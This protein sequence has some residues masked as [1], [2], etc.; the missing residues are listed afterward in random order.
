M[1]EKLEIVKID[2]QYFKKYNTTIID[3]RKVRINY[4]LIQELLG[5]FKFNTIIVLIDSVNKNSA[6]LEEVLNNYQVKF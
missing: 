3:V 6:L 4:N 5:I 1:I 2:R